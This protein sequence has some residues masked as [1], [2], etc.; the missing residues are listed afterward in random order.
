MVIKKR[1]ISLT[2]EFWKIPASKIK[3][4]LKLDNQTLINS[5]SIRFYQYIA[6]IE[7][8]L[9]VKVKD[10]NKIRTFGDLVNNISSK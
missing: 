9:G 1:L 4:S 5:S 6:A 8:N 3:D 7:S 2:S 10:L